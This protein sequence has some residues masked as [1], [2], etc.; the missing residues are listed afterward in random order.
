MKLKIAFL[1]LCF[2]PFCISSQNLIANGG[3]DSIT[4]CP[5][6]I[7]QVSLAKGWF[8]SGSADLFCTCT[9]SR[10]V[11][12]AGLN[13]AGSLSP[14]SG[15]CYSGFIVNPQYK[16]YVTYLLP[17]KLKRRKTYCIRFLYARSIFSGIKVNS[18]GVYAHKEMHRGAVRGKP[19]QQKTAATKIEDHPGEWTS[20]S[21]TFTCKGG[22]RFISIGSFNNDLEKAEYVFA[23][24]NK[25]NVPVFN[26]T[27]SGY[28]FIDD[29][30]L[31][32]LQTGE[33]CQPI[34]L[35]VDTVK[36]TP[37]EPVEIDT[38]RATKLFVLQQ[39]N[40]ETNKSD[41]LPSSFD[42]LDELADYLISQPELNLLIMGHTDNQGNE[43]TNLLLSE[44]RAKAVADYLALKEVVYERIT[45]K[46]FGS[47]RPIASNETE[48]GRSKNR[49]VEFQVN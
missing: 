17:K 38:V 6:R 35:P 4:K 37:L 46:G 26:Y 11:V 43:K 14:H 2:Y 10:S 25:K 19:I 1:L 21:F 44:A 47:S 20:V 16:E 5:N 34:P 29:I 36:D 40:F 33:T 28:Y 27:S 9:S 41:I 45:W 8:S 39:L 30:E 24:K 49:R 32:Q 48:E 23:K 13:F 12:Y 15:N 7:S 3:F 31:I 22:E 18:L 42:E